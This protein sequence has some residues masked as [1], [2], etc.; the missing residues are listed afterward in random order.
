MPFLLGSVNQSLYCMFPHPLFPW[1]LGFGVGKRTSNAWL[2]VVSV[3]LLF[4]VNRFEQ[5]KLEVLQ[6]QPHTIE[7][8]LW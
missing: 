7:D 4:K 6:M 3:Y 5:L 2:C 8:E 1:C